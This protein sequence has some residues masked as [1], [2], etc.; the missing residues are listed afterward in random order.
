MPIL[1]FKP[2]SVPYI[3]DGTKRH[4]IRANRKRPIL[5][6]DRLV[7][8][9]GLRQRSG[10]QLLLETTCSS[11]E[12][13][14]IFILSKDMKRGQLVIRVQGIPLNTDEQ[15]RLAWRDGFR[16]PGSTED[17]PGNSIDLMMEFWRGRLPFYG[18]IIHWGPATR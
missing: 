15:S 1:N 9:T 16:P 7:L 4:T 13:I 14:D 2:Q 3:L 5:P 8:Y 17:A 11:V 12:N 6:G 10:A 18:Q